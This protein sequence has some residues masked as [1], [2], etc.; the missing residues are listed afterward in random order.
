MK[1][2]LLAFAVAATISACHYGVEEAKNT[3]DANEQYKSDKADYSVNRA[4]VAAEGA[5]PAAA[6]TAAADTSAHK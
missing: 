2:M 3:L 4:N 5:A 1:K 6:D